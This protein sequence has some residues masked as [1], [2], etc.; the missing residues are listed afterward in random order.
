MFDIFRLLMKLSIFLLDDHY[1]VYGARVHVCSVVQSCLSPCDPADHGPGSSVHG[2]LQANVLE[3]VAVPASYGIILY[4]D[5][6]DEWGEL[7]FSRIFN[8]SMEN[9]TA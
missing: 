8:Y 7:S 3:W 9:K 1:D 2:I 5:M 4:Y 6:K